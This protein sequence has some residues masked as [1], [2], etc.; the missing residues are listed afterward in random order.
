MLFH[1]K[2]KMIFLRI[3]VILLFILKKINYEK[4]SFNFLFYLLIRQ[5][6]IILFEMLIKK[7]N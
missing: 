1:K 4:C 2:I 5:I 7:N 6:V 3:K